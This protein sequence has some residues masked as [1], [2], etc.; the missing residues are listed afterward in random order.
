MFRLSLNQPFS[1]KLAIVAPDCAEDMLNGRKLILAYVYGFLEMY[2]PP[3]S[4]P[5]SEL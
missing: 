3:E 2:L 1:G 5:K 4:E